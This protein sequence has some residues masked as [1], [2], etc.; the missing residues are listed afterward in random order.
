VLV[1]GAASTACMGIN[2]GFLFNVLFS[3]L[4][5]YVGKQRYILLGFI[6]GSQFV[7]LLVFKLV[8]F[9]QI[10]SNETDTSSK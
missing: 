9:N 10:F 5:K 6:G 3:E 7:L 8:F 1:Y 4:K 2:R